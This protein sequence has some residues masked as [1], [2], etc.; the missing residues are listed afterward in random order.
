[1]APVAARLVAERLRPDKA[2]QLTANSVFQSI[3]GTVLK[4]I[5]AP[6]RPP[7]ALLAARERR[8][9]RRRCSVDVAIYARIF[10]IAQ[11]ILICV[12]LGG[13]GGLQRDLVYRPSVP[14]PEYGQEQLHATREAYWP[15]V[16]RDAELNIGEVIYSSKLVW[17]FGP[18][19]AFPTFWEK[20][21][22]KQG[23]LAIGVF[24]AAKPGASIRFDLR[25]FTVILQDGRSFS[26]ALAARW[27]RSDLEPTGP[28]T[29]SGGQD[30][31]GRL[32]YD[33]PLMDMRPFELR[34]GALDVN[35]QTLQLPEIPFVRAK[36]YSG[37]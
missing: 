7:R 29:L 3:S 11:W 36:S 32:Q 33:L 30:W 23:L 21:V 4:I 10:A 34:L 28:V 2:L 15:L 20:Y 37:S 18:F 22:P 9:A 16:L 1:L 19:F 5:Q 35:G 25:E 31:R 8:A 26:P 14:V 27:G 17:V 24:V 12:L 13:C 6:R